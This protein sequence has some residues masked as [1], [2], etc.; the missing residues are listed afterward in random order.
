[1]RKT[2]RE[3]VS[4]ATGG[5]AGPDRSQAAQRHYDPGGTEE[6]T[7]AIVY[8]VA[9]AEDRPAGELRSPPL[10]ESVDA[11]AL[12]RT[13]FGSDVAGE[14]RQGVGTVEF[15]YAGYLVAVRSDGWIQVYESVGP[16]A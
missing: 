4:D 16:D 3:G 12:E 6:L 15:R 5:A 1:M 11:A 8:A 14:S 7:A 10:Y 2:E 9:D 13:F